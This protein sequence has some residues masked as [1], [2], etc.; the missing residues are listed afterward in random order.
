ARAD[1]RAV[2]PNRNGNGVRK[3]PAQSHGPNRRRR[4]KGESGKGV[5]FLPPSA[6]LLPPSNVRR[7]TEAVT[8]FRFPHHPAQPEKGDRYVEVECAEGTVS[9]IVSSAKAGPGW[10][11]AR[12]ARLLRLLA[13]GLLALGAVCA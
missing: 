13:P 10:L 4:A 5:R 3:A 11:T 9:P 8:S 1:S 7:T 2:L 12:P 6:F